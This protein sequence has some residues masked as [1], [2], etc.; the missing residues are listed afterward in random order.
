MAKDKKPEDVVKV[1]P[2]PPIPKVRFLVWFTGALDRFQGVKAHHM[3]AVQTYFASL[4]LAE[5]ETI[6]VYDQG[7]IKFGYGK[8]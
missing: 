3:H 4:G 1:K 7:L 6:E 2:A 8:K 5:P